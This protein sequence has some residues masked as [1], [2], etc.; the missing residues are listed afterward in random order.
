[1]SV[2]YT[3]RWHRTVKTAYRHPPHPLPVVITSTCGGSPMSTPRIQ[4]TTPLK[5]H[6]RQPGKRWALRVLG[7]RFYRTPRVGAS[8][9]VVM[10]KTIGQ[11]KTYHTLSVSKWR[12]T[13]SEKQNASVPAGFIWSYS[14][15]RRW[16]RDETG[17]G[18]PTHPPTHS[19]TSSIVHHLH[20]ASGWTE[21]IKSTLRI[22]IIVLLRS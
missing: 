1:M 13:I 20:V 15:R 12:N 19:S 4:L 9:V 6:F 16:A 5:L 8:G 11:K 17:Y 18:S 3:Q 21:I 7:R 2:C 10:T 14:P 22:T